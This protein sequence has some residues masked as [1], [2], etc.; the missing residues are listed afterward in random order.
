MELDETRM[1]D[2]IGKKTGNLLKTQGLEGQFNKSLKRVHQTY[3]EDGLLRCGDHI[4]LLNK[5]TN[6]FAVMDI[7]ARAAGADE[8]YAV[9]T[10]K[11]D[12]GPCAR[13]IFVLAAAEPQTDKVLRYNQ[14][15]RLTSS[16]YLHAKKLFLSSRPA[17]TQNYSP[18][19][20]QQEVTVHS[21]S[22]F[23][24]VWEV[25][26]VNPNV[27]FENAGQPVRAN[28]AILLKHVSTHHYISSDEKPIKNDYGQEYEVSVYSTAT[29]NKSQNLALEQTGK[30]TRDFPSKFQ[31]DQNIWMFVTAPDPSFAIPVADE[32]GEPVFNMQVFLNELKAKLKERGSLGLRG[33]G[34]IFKAMDDN[35][36]HLLDVD[37]FR[38]GLMD[39]G[40]QISKEEANEV[41]KFFDRDGNGSVDFNEFIRTLRGDMNEC[42]KAIVHKAYDKLDVS[43]DGQVTLEDI[44][45]LYDAG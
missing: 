7:G 1:N 35:G 32:S 39:Y 24:T 16:P 33:L 4:M 37:D 3:S 43:K 6:G 14:K 44:S 22:D 15:V 26:H 13:S 34:R 27:R 18:V 36:N 31:Q 30:V 25:E 38:W 19:T 45:K 23:N 41:L 28:E 8:A 29:N 20:R 21:K 11:Q 5:K 17:T 40:F 42:R 10:T 2:H 12:T 9:S